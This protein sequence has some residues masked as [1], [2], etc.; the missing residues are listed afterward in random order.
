MAG[1]LSGQTPNDSINLARSLRDRGDLDQAS[2]V[3][4]Q[5]ASH[6][7]DFNVFWL[8]AETVYRQKHFNTALALYQEAIRLAPDNAYLQLDYARKLME[9][10]H[11]HHAEEILNKLTEFDV[12]QKAALTERTR[13]LYWRNR[14]HDA[15]L[16]LRKLLDQNPKDNDLL[17]LQKNITISAAPWLKLTGSFLSDTQPLKTFTPSIES[18]KTFNNYFS[19]FVGFYLPVYT[20]NNKSVNTVSAIVGNKFLIPRSAISFVVNGGI[21]RQGNF[22]PCYIGGL[23]FTKSFLG[24]AAVS[25]GFERK[26]YLSTVAS[27][28]TPVKTNHTFANLTFGQF[29]KWNGKLSFDDNRFDDGNRVYSA[30]GYFFTPTIHAG[31][32][33]MSVGYCFT[34]NNSTADRFVSDESLPALLA[35]GNNQPIKGHY[36]PY[37]TPEQQRIHAAL[38]NI[39]IFFSKKMKIGFTGNGSFAATAN[40]PYFYLQTGRGAS[41][42][43]VKDFV[44][45]Q[46]HPYE[47]TFFV[48]VFT[49][50]T[51]SIRMEYTRKSTLFYESH[52]AGLSFYTKLLRS[53]RA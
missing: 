53:W 50:Q 4:R 20:V 48:Q 8:Y 13:I 40:V 42:T 3:L 43:L 29:G 25:A 49:G 44:P 27:L 14:P 11:Y 17:E 32:L 24:G 46:Y 9:T 12:T 6:T 23:T 47:A 7:R 15:G 10:R 45:Y 22:S 2:D 5:L 41:V 31:A 34:W 1:S 21:F 19:P 26:P 39:E 37:F 30:Y 28:E 52:Y 16:L 18:G 33:H 36:V 38:A 51:A 35:Q